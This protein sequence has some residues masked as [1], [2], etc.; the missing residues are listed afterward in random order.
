MSLAQRYNFSF[1]GI[2]KD[3]LFV[4]SKSEIVLP[5]VKHNIISIPGR[6]GGFISETRLEMRK[7][8]VNIEIDI[9]VGWTL[10]DV[11]EDLADYLFSEKEEEL[12]F[13]T[14]TDRTYYARIENTS[15]EPIGQLAA[16]GRLSFICPDGL[17]Y[18][19]QKEVTLQNGT[20]NNIYVYGTKDTP[21]V[22]ECEPTEP[23][24]SLSIITPN[25]YLRVGYEEDLTAS[26]EKEQSILH[27]PGSQ[28]ATWQEGT[29]VDGGI[30]QGT[31]KTNSTAENAGS[32]I[33][34]A[35][36]GIVVPNNWY[37]PA[38][39]YTLPEQLQDFKIEAKLGNKNLLIPNEVARIE[40]YLL[41]SNKDVIAKMSMADIKPNVIENIGIVQLRK[42]MLNKEWNMLYTNAWQQKTFLDF[43]GAMRIQRVGNLFYAYITRIDTKGN[44]YGY[45]DAWYRDVN[46]DFMD[47]VAYVQVHFGKYDNYPV[48]QRMFIDQLTVIKINQDGDK[49]YIARPG[50]K[51]EIDTSKRDIRV[52]GDSRIWLKDIQTQHFNLKPGVNV[53]SVVPPVPTKIKWRERYL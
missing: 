4:T 15:L 41:N 5:P 20:E 38:K 22:L 46:G 52:N 30:V 23:L 26:V 27:I 9:P 31:V 17:K 29:K 33:Q 42:D 44:N 18:G 28:M 35:D 50:D 39:I 47:K 14:A 24:T 12:I 21:F 10:E 1:K 53:L 49:Q 51:I 16:V 32:E 3:Y 11:K 6:D 7:I 36:F 2:T 8:D 13:T 45:V 48:Q 40:I 43:Y 19:P 34:P 37:G 25:D